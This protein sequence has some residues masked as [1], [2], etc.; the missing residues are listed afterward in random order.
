LRRLQRQEQQNQRQKE[1]EQQQKEFLRRQQEEEAAAQREKERREAER[2]KKIKQVEA[3]GTQ[4]DEEEPAESRKKAVK[5]KAMKP[6]NAK[7]MVAKRITP[8]TLPPQQPEDDDSVSEENQ[9]ELG[10]YDS[11]LPE[12]PDDGLLNVLSLDK[13]SDSDIDDEPSMVSLILPATPNSP[14]RQPSPMKKR[15]LTP[16]KRFAK[17]GGKPL[18][19]NFTNAE[20]KRQAK[21]AE[22]AARPEEGESDGDEAEPEPMPAPS[23]ST[24]KKRLKRRKEVAKKADGSA[25]SKSLMAAMASTAVAVKP[26]KGVANGAAEKAT[27]SKGNAVR[28]KTAGNSTNNGTSKSGQA[29]SKPQAKKTKAPTEEEGNP[30]AL[31]VKRKVGGKAATMSIKQRLANAEL[32]ARMGKMQEMSTPKVLCKK[33][34]KAQQQGAVK[35]QAAQRTDFGKVLASEDAE[36][37]DVPRR[38]Q[39]IEEGDL[40]ISLN[41][42]GLLSDND[43]PENLRAPSRKRPREAAGGDVTPTKKLQ[44]L[45]ITKRLAKSPMPRFL[46]TPTPLMSPVV[47]SAFTKPRAASPGPRVRSAAPTRRMNSAPV[48]PKKTTANRFGVP[49]GVANPAA[50]G[51]GFSM[52]DAFVN[53]GSSGGIPRL[54]T[55]TGGGESP[56]V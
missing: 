8:V 55:K 47:S 2:L 10:G 43:S 28:N 53:S 49:A 39:M 52:F 3:S 17:K 27:S 50:S 23:M 1:I 40:N 20:A 29:K 56:S 41:S 48:R 54:K 18:D 21:A 30:A 24:P 45:E 31:S 25:G 11:P 38:D 36:Q 4:T 16:Q 34:R 9:N 35:T 6:K 12:L 42:S 44:F 26:K 32:L 14:K 19:F 22:A 51:G 7:P 5:P 13:S 46:R 15:T 33:T 37:E